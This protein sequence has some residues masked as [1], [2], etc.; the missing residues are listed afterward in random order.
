MRRTFG[1][2]LW[3]DSVRWR[4]ALWYALALGVVLLV[5]AGGAYA[6]LAHL[7]THRSDHFLEQ[8]RDMFVNELRSEATTTPDFDSAINVARY[9][10][11][12][13][14]TRF[15]IFD[16]TLR[17]RAPRDTASHWMHPHADGLELWEFPA[18]KFASLVDARRTI[19]EKRIIFRNKPAAGTMA[20]WPDSAGG[21]RA[22]FRILTVEGTP[23]IVMAMQSRHDLR[24]VLRSI[25]WAFAGAIPICLALATFIGY[26]LAQGALS[27]IAIMSRRAREISARNLHARL[28][29]G[30][31][32]DELGELAGMINEL[33]EMSFEQQRRFVNDASHELRTPVAIIR[34]ESEVVLAQPERDEGEYRTSMRVV[35]SAGAKLSRI[36]DDLFLLTSADTGDQTMS[37]REVYLDD[38]LLDATHA[39]R[40]LAAKRGTHVV[41]QPSPTGEEKAVIDGDA[42]LLGRV[43]LN[44]LDNAIKYSPVGAVVSVKLSVGATY[45]ITVTDQGHGIPEEVQPF[46]FQRF[47]RADKTLGRNT[48]AIGGAGLGL[49]IARW[50]TE[51]HGGTLDLVRSD[52]KGSEF[53]VSLPRRRAGTTISSD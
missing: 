44:L 27:P 16:S 15:V 5:F 21:Y 42:E 38:L 49:S 47:F 37:T 50:L 13:R 2:R 18:E 35:Q 17:I 12:F 34:A 51:L 10:V 29:V 33:L 30:N 32:R 39:V 40:T 6:A 45:D 36:V 22:A 25:A 43:L 53:R 26:L 4:L 28:P 14:D 8:T 23:Y 24:T 52:A 1:F 9:D 48:T 7:V 20:S 31:P 3:P 19:A 46:I 41:I 11:R